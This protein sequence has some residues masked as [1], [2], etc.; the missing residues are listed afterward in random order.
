MELARLYDLDGVVILAFD[1]WVVE[2]QL[3][4][5]LAPVGGL[6][7]VADWRKSRHRLELTSL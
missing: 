4:S 3:E 2:E 5:L 7:G 1:L 6:A